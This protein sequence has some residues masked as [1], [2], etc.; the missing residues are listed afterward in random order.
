MP[1]GKASDLQRKLPRGQTRLPDRAAPCGSPPTGSREAAEDGRVSRKRL[2]GASFRMQV[3]RATRRIRYGVTQRIC[4]ALSFC[5]RH[6]F[7][8]RDGPATVFTVQRQPVRSSACAILSR[9]ACT[10]ARGPAPAGALTRA[11]G[12]GDA[13]TP[14]VDR[15]R[16]SVTILVIDGD[17]T[18]E[19]DPETE[20]MLLH[21][22]AQ[23]RRGE[24]TPLTQFLDEL[25]NR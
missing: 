17:G 2:S 9:A 25:R 1:P 19:A 15:R 5:E 16:A 23:C 11:A 18:F 20:K 12:S 6:R 22:I 7:L 13:R 21:A 4:A 8:V 10:R 3:S 14:R 24:T